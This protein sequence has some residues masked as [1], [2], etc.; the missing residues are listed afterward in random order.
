MKKNN[1]Q[2]QSQKMGM[3]RRTKNT[4]EYRQTCGDEDGDGDN[5]A[6][7]GEDGYRIFYRVIIYCRP[8]RPVHTEYSMQYS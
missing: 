4:T 6:G 5:I 3:G 7:W 2:K 1:M 8:L